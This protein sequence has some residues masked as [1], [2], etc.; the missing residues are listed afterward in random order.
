MKINFYLHLIN[1]KEP[2]L[3]GQSPRLYQPLKNA[4]ARFIAWCL[5]HL[6]KEEILTETKQFLA[7]PLT[8]QQCVLVVSLLTNLTLC[9]I[10]PAAEKLGK[11]SERKP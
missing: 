6:P 9:H 10:L 2:G 1:I 8:E 7:L 3:S 4:E 5:R 11:C